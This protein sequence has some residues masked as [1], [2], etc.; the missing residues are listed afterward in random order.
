MNRNF[1]KIIIQTVFPLLFLLLVNA[2]FKITFTGY[3]FVCAIALFWSIR[4]KNQGQ[5]TSWSVILVASI[6]VTLNYLRPI[7]VNEVVSYNNAAHNVLVLRGVEADK[8]L[9]LIDSANSDVALFDSEDY[10]GKVTANANANGNIDLSC[11]LISHP[12]FCWQDNKFQIVNKNSFPFFS[13][14]LEFRKKSGDNIKLNIEEFDDSTNYI[15]STEYNGVTLVDTAS[16]SKHIKEG[17]QLADVLST[18]YKEDK[19][20]ENFVSDLKGVYLVRNNIPCKDAISESSP[21]YITIPR[22][23]LSEYRQGLVTVKCDGIPVNITPQNTEVQISGDQKVY[24]G[25]GSTKTRPITLSNIGGI[26]R[27]RYYMPYMYNFPVDT[28]VVSSHTLAISSNAEDLLS[29]DVKAAF[30]F[31][32]FNSASNKNNFYGTISYQTSSTPNPLDIDF[33]DNIGKT[34][35][36]EKDSLG[37]RLNTLNKTKWIVDVVDI[38]K[39]SPISG[40]RVWYNDWFILGLIIGLSLFALFCYNI[41]K[42]DETIHDA[43]ANGVLNA[44]LFFIS[45]LTLRL[46]LI[47]RI[48]IFPPVEGISKSEF[49]LYRLENGLS[50]N[51]MV[52]TFGAIAIMIL[53]TISLYVLEKWGKQ[54]LNTNKICSIYSSRRFWIVLGC[55]IIVSIAN[56]AVNLPNSLKVL[57]NVVFPVVLFFINEWRCI[58]GLSV[59]HRIVSAIAVVGMLVIGDAGYAIMFIIFECVYFI[60]LAIAYKRI[61]PNESTYKHAIWKCVVVLTILILLITLFAPQIICYLYNSTTVLGIDFIKVFHVAFAVIIKVSQVAFSVI[62]MLLVFAVN[63]VIRD[64]LTKKQKKWFKIVS[65]VCVVAFVVVGPFFFNYMGHFKYRSLIHTQNVGQIMEY[66]DVSKRDSHRLLEASQNQWFLQ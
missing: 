54:K 39:T 21:L 1:I 10:F 51:S 12:I 61:T 52:W 46:Y 26:V 20:R 28:M 24:I 38:R 56:K 58:K 33:V 35:E 47:W 36:V 45:L 49:T 48:A 66:E 43:K 18:C 14:S 31:D 9:N 50:D 30:Y 8:Q 41:I 57:I 4:Y 37:F 2:F 32:I 34:K 44:W 65:S 27:A 13:K 6:L 53:G 5:Y 3:F 63:Y 40:E 7:S 17:Y 62:G 11:N 16:F 64:I 29:S 60:I 19:F 23:L 59:I 15:V 55:F 42:E 25:I 22:T